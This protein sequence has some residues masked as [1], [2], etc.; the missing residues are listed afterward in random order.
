MPL[1]FQFLRSSVKVPY[2]F[3][4]PE[5]REKYEG[6]ARENIRREIDKLTQEIA[7]ESNPEAADWV[8]IPS[9]LINRISGTVCKLVI[10]GDN[11]H[12][13]ALA[14]IGWAFCDKYRNH[15]DIVCMR[16]HQ[17]CYVSNKVTLSISWS[18]RVCQLSNFRPSFINHLCFLHF[19][20][21]NVMKARIHILHTIY[22][23][24][25]CRYHVNV[26]F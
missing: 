20:D 1:N 6:P 18:G 5:F 13:I 19:A 14:W 22:Y 3:A 2:I 26:I 24:K 16:P 12:K 8:K 17:R 15:N 9:H 11:W 25:P 4:T 7:K 23:N 10:T 21:Q